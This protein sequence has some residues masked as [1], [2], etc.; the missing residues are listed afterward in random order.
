M[1]EQTGLDLTVR[2][3]VQGLEAPERLARPFR[4]LVF[5]WDG[6]AVVNRQEEASVLVTLADALLQ[7]NVWLVIVTGTNYG[8]IDRQFC[9]FVMPERRH[10]LLVCTNRGSEVFGFDAAGRL[11]RRFART[12][13]PEEEMALDKTA[14]M[15]RDEI[16]RE[17]GL[18]INIVYDRLNRRKI[19]LIPLPEWADPPKSQIGELLEA[20]ERRLSEAGWSG[21]L[22]AAIQLTEQAARDQGLPDARITSD[23]KHIEVGL[24]DKGDSVVWVRQH[25]FAPAGIATDDVLIVGDEFGAIGGFVGSD[26]RLR[27]EGGDAVV[28]SVG[29][30]PNGVPS[31]VIHLGG[32][33]E[34]F[35]ALLAEQV[36]YHRQALPAP[37]AGIP[38]WLESAL[39]PPSD[40]SWR[41]DEPTY[42]PA[43]EHQVESC[44]TVANGAIGVRGS[45][46][47]PTIASAPLTLVAGLYDTP[48]SPMAVPALVP[49]PNWPQWQIAIDGQP[50]AFPSEEEYP[51]HRTLDLQR[52]VLLSSWTLQD[53]AERRLH[54]RSLRFASLADR[55]LVAQVVVLTVDQ[56]VVVQLDIW[57]ETPEEWLTLESAA[58]DLFVWQTTGTG[59]RL[60]LAWTASLRVD[61]VTHPPD[62]RNLR[63]SWSWVATPG[64]VAILGRGVALAR[65]L[66]ET[67]PDPSE[68]VRRAIRRFEHGGLGQSFV[69]HVEAWAK[70]W[71]EGDVVI[72]G[73]VDAQ[74]A[75]RFALYHLNS[76]ANPDDER[77]SV[78]ARA[79]TG[80]AYLGHVFW[81]ASIFVLPYYIFTWPAAAR[82]ALMYRYHTLPAA[83][84]KA[85]KLGYRGALYAWESADTGEEATPPYV[86]NPAGQVVEILNG[87]Q[88]QHISA[89]IAYAVW[90]YWQATGDTSFLLR[91]GAEIILETARFWASRATLEADGSYHIRGVIG[92]DEY[93][94]G[95]DDNAFTN[96]MATWNIERG[97][98]VADLLADR[99][100]EHWDDLRR[101]LGLTPN[102]RDQW[103]DVAARLTPGR[104]IDGV[105]EQFAGFFDLEF[106]DL[107]AYEPRTIPFDVLLGAARVQRSQVVKQADVVMLL[108]LLWDRFPPEVRAASFDY[109]EPR[110]GHGSS[111]SPAIHALVAARLGKLDLAE[112]YFRQ[113]AAIDL[114]DMMSNA[115]MGVH[116]AA[117]GGLWQA[118]VFGFAGLRLCAD[119]IA[120]D[121]R[122]PDS[123]EALRFPL[124][125]RGRALHIEIV[126]ASQ[127][128]TVTLHEGHPMVIRVGDVVGHLMRGKAFTCR[129]GAID[130]RWKEVT[131]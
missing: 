122:L 69:N 110:T 98:E 62:R 87:T 124:R 102:E 96:V 105:I 79:L 57:L 35:R 18:D 82:A 84:E 32:G 27:V 86:V 12:A 65:E 112:D 64:Q 10:H 15:V 113:T 118:A 74:R 55:D 104:I 5:D 30:E 66:P 26:D 34:R 77:V 78:G 43:I 17:T 125:W 61:G 36:W 99:W 22:G 68:R 42:H 48:A 3:P 4:A 128:V 29:P 85:R 111:L 51:Y 37:S 116:I 115:A 25:L 89:D 76:A 46:D 28:V 8:H 119:G 100:P 126:K 127:Q 44:F 107:A 58:S 88:E 101:R 50:V 59:K 81:D 33:P 11:Q 95:V 92:P 114:D 54:A 60:A 21:G 7:L 109:Y 56:P 41:L 67:A 47:Q 91:A 19:D 108:A 16:Q 83:R 97:L 103:R 31:G 45:L 13:T 63:I 6:T 71:R 23:V 20:V 129:W 1:V 38:A 93:H 94:E 14:E 49:A 131:Q 70:R 53:D 73:D 123:W 9:R 52:G 106:I 121:P 130:G 2:P 72:D 120:L 24:T 90:Q 80:E 117:Q 75:M 39:T 40:P